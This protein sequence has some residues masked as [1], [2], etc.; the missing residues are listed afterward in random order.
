MQLNVQTPPSSEVQ[1]NGIEP[2]VGPRSFRKEQREFFFGRDEEADELVSI[3]TAHSAVLLYSQ[4]GA[5]K[6]S[7]LNAKLIPKLEEAESFHV[8]QSMRVQGQLPATLKIGRKTNIFVLNALMSSGQVDVTRTNMNMTFHEFVAQLGQQTNEYGEPAPI[9]MVF[10][11][12][13][14]LFTSYPG[15]WPDRED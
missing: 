7:L 11:Q 2:Y 4:S 13:E 14:E 6:T 15:R 10:D 8:L 3:I 12:F 5:G 9:V 1:T